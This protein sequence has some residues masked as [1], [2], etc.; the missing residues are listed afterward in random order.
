MTGAAL[1]SET[2]T[3]RV[4]EEKMAT[5]EMVLAVE[6]MAD[7][8]VVAAARMGEVAKSGGATVFSMA[9]EELF[10]KAGRL[11]PR[12]VCLSAHF[13]SC[14]VEVDWRRVVVLRVA[15]VEAGRRA[16]R[17]AGTEAE[18]EAEVLAEADACRIRAAMVG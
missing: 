9:A 8:A 5:A 18:Q 15:A 7:M 4:A 1:G 2:V 3:A 14:V 13:L 10:W 16:G 12:A 17:G 6:A 11:H